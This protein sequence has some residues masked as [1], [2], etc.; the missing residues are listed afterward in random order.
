MWAR[1]GSRTPPQWPGNRRHLEALH[2]VDADPLV[3]LPAGP[4]AQ[5]GDADLVTGLLACLWCRSA[6]AAPAVAG[7]D[8]VGELVRQ[9]GQVPYKTPVPR[10]WWRR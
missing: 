4:L 10:W 7:G 3:R 2:Q 5:L 8:L 6:A 1:F 9:A